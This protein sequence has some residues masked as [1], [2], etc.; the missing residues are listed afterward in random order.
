G[1]DSMIIL[2]LGE[3]NARWLGWRSGHTPVK[4]ARQHP[5]LPA[6]RPPPQLSGD[7]PRRWGLSGEG[8]AFGDV[9]AA[10]TRQDKQAVVG[11]LAF[12]AGRAGV[13]LAVAGLAARRLVVLSP[14]PVG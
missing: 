7:T 3:S 11:Q 12:S 8:A 4:S 2:D 13:A 6:Q 9:V 5:R 14:P 10:G 1:H